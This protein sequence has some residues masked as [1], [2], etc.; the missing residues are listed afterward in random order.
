MSIKLP[1]G[2]LYLEYPEEKITDSAGSEI[3]APDDNKSYD[4]DN[5]GLSHSYLWPVLYSWRVSQ[6][7]PATTPAPVI[8]RIS[9]RVNHLVQLYNCI[10]NNNNNNSNNNSDNNYDNNNNS[11]KNDDN[12]SNCN[13]K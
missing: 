1:R 7:N 11:S 2:L 13:N 9:S 6:Y 4:G 3:T 5:P 10:N 12:H 8:F